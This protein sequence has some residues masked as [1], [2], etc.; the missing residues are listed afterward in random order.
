VN[1]AAS[2]A[3]IEQLTLVLADDAVGH[4]QAESGAGFLG[5]EMRLE[6]SVAVVV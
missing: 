5:R 4:E 6:Q 1:A 3:F 2:A